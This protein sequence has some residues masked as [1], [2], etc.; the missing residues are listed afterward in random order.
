MLPVISLQKVLLRRER[1]TKLIEMNTENVKIKHYA[2]FIINRK[3]IFNT[4]EK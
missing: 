4:V 1:D 3:V 2:D